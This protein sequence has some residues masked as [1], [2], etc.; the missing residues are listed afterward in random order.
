MID[1]AMDALIE[2][3]EA[4]KL[5]WSIDDRREDGAQF[6]WRYRVS[7]FDH[8]STTHNDLATAICLSIRQAAQS[9]GVKNG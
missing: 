7:I 5:Q 3:C 6:G 8:C 2:F 1:A 4:R 9:V